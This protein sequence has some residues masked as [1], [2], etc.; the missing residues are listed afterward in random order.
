MQ[1][2][3][4]HKSRFW[5]NS[6]LSKIA[7]CAKCQKHLPTVQWSSG[8][9]VQLVEYWTHNQEDACSTHAQSTASNLEQVA[10]LLCA[11]D[12][13]MLMHSIAW[14]KLS[15]GELWSLLTTYRNSYMGFSKN[16]LLDP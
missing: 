14:H 4:R 9:V 2:G 8:A 10:N 13:A 11:Q 6:W 3:Y 7:G 12:N 16:P 1:V 15:S 5:S